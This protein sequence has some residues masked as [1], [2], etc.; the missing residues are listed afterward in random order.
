MMPKPYLQRDEMVNLSKTF[1]L[2][3]YYP[4]KMWPI[5]QKAETDK[6]LWEGLMNDYKEN[7]YFGEYQSGGVDK[8]N[9]LKKYCV[10]HDI[11][12]TFQWETMVTA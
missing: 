6:K 2:Y 5:I 1:S 8:I 3:A 12:S 7:F 10:K 9:H 11:S 4:D